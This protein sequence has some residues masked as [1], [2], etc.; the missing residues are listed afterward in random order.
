VNFLTADEAEARLRAA[1]GSAL[2]DRLRRIK[3]TYDPENLLRG[4][5]NIPPL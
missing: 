3:T 5:L 1:Y 2:Y 4:N